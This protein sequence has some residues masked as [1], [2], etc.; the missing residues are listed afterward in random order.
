[1]LYGSHPYREPVKR[2]V[3]CV[4][5]IGSRCDIRS[6]RCDEKHPTAA[7]AILSRQDYPKNSMG[8]ISTFY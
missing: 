7:L 8:G 3:R 6:Y 2:G 4:C 5:A 1:M